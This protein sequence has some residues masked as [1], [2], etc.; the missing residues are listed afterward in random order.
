MDPDEALKELLLLA[1][2]VLA[3]TQSD[4]EAV[5]LAEGVTELHDWISG[6]GFPPAAW[7]ATIPR[8]RS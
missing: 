7:D 6:G 4:P 8:T 1:R 5:R 2:R 3:D